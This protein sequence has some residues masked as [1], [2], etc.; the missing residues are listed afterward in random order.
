MTVRRVDRE[1][2]ISLPLDWRS[3]SLKGEKEVVVVEQ[4]DAL[5][6]RPRRRPDITRYFDSVEVDVDP[7][8]FADYRQL[9]HALLSE[10]KKEGR[11]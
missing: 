10:E 5:V 8:V 7:S 3:R 1:G 2:R 9:K 6:I 11:P 4:D